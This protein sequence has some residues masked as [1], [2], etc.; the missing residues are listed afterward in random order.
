MSSSNKVILITG[1]NTGLGLETVKVL[2][3]DDEAYDIIIGSR[4]VSKGEAA[5]ESVKKEAQQSSS[6]ISVVQVDLTSDESITQALNTIE[7]KFGRLD[8]LINNGG[9]NFDG[10][11]QT[12]DLSIREAWNASWD[13]NVAGT[14][15]LTHGAVPLLCKSS[16]PRLLFLT[17]GTSSISE[18][19]DPTNPVLQR[20]N[21]VPEA[22][23]PKPTQINPIEAYRSSKAGLNMMMRQWYR[24]LLK[25]GVK[26]WA[27]SPGFLATGL[28]GIGREQLLKMGAREPIEGANFIRD[29]IKGKHDEDAGKAI[30]AT[31]IQPW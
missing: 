30:R 21:A 20:I 4:S 18:T 10:Q 9:S 6:S 17:S 14:Q 25:D 24:I 2:Y 1:G 13:V 15:V 28:G 19:V 31:M 5:A 11:I 7:S 22:G 8:V 23:W 16:D 26:V 29:V 12:G 3:K 27:I